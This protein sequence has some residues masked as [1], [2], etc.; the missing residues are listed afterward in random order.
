[1]ELSLHTSKWDFSFFKFQASGNDFVLIEDRNETFPSEDSSLIAKICDRKRGVGGDGILLL[2]HSSIAFVK[3]R[4][5][6]ADGKE[7]FLCGNGLRIVGYFLLKEKAEAEVLVETKA[8]LHRICKKKGEIWVFFPLPKKMDTFSLS[9]FQRKCKADLIDAGVRHLLIED[10]QLETYDSLAFLKEH[11]IKYDANISLYDVRGDY[12]RIRT[13]ERGVEEETD[14]CG[15]ATVSLASLFLKSHQAIHY[16][17]DILR[18]SYHEDNIAL[19]G[20][21]D[22]VFSGRFNQE[23]SEE[24]KQSNCYSSSL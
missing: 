21:V 24:K 13:Y 22:F 11:R 5:F 23:A 14:S 17:R 18:V 1:M 7:A 8:G 15:T 6:N 9:L 16:S 3:M 20:E 4:I 12:L 2:Q 19:C 10:P